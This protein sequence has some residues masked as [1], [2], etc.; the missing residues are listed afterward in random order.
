MKILFKVKQFIESNNLLKNGDRVLLAVSGGPDSMVLLD[1]MQN[2]SKI[3]DFEIGVAH[4]N[5]QIRPDS[6]K[7]LLFVENLCK[8]LNIPFYGRDIYIFGGRK[9]QKKSLEQKAREERYNA[10]KSIADEFGYNLIATGHTKSDQA[11]TILMRILSGTNI[12][13]LS[14]ILAKRDGKII[15]PLL[16]LTRSEIMEYANRNKLIFVEDITNRD[17]KYLRNKI[18]LDLIP[19]IKKEFNPSIEEALSS[20]AEDAINLREFIENALIHH[21]NKTKF[22]DDLSVAHISKKEFLKIPD[23]LKKYFLFEIL[24][25][26]GISKRIDS[27]NLKNAIECIKVTE[28]SRFYNLT[29]EMVIRCEYDKISIGRFQDIKGIEIELENFQPIKVKKPGIYKIDW[30]DIEI[31]F[32][33]G[34]NKKPQYPDI[35]INLEKF[36]FPFYIRVF[37]DGDRIYSSHYKKYVKLKK[38]FINKKIPVRFRRLFPIICSGDEIL[39]V[40]GVTRSGIG[41]PEK[42]DKQITITIYNFEP[43][44]NKY[45]GPFDINSQTL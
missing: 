30:L 20:L 23:E 5:H 40:P 44:F 33:E 19:Y 36:S 39:W 4:I 8:K 31:E 43:E 10:L 24:S 6:H 26:I 41:L 28:G 12:K 18:R 13:S 29:P 7:D 14:G 11:E 34:K 27:E 42:G 21:I 38:I 15:R 17:R 16:A 45:L 3:M 25:K 9:S 32:S 1:I 22:D 2:L 35:S 37:E